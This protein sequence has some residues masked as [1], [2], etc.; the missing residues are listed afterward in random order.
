MKPRLREHIKKIFEDVYSTY[1][2]GG[3]ATA[4]PQQGFDF[5]SKSFNELPEEQR[6]EIANNQFEQLKSDFNGDENKAMENLPDHLKLY[7]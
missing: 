4:S 3:G 5:G 6:I 7:I 2:Y 1:L